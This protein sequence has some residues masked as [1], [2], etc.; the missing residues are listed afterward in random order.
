MKY[1]TRLIAMMGL[2]SGLI[3]AGCAGSSSNSST[4]AGGNAAAAPG[5]A[6]AGAAANASGPSMDI[7]KVPPPPLER[8]R[9]PWRALFD[10]RS[11]AGWT[12]RGGQAE[13][14]AADG[15]IVGATRPDQPNSFL[16]TDETFGD[17][18]LEL[19][20]IVDPQLN[21]GIQ[22][23]SEYKTEGTKQTVFGYQVE[24]DPSAR[25]WTGG[26]YDEARRGWLMNL[27]KNPEAKK[28]FKQGQ[29]NHFRI[30]AQGDHIQTWLNGTP[31]TDFHDGMTPK[32]FFGLQVHAVAKGTPELTVRWRNI[33][34]RDLK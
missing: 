31:A 27:D 32:G 9:P 18:E 14:H 23:R 1:T 3:L 21:S 5:T 34:L 29:W 26:L 12:L 15:S 7:S 22:I 25:A 28:A 30:V 13:Y 8:I 20:F 17:F 24:I 10:G 2:T 33:K 19:D 4:S 16:C 11:L 6:T